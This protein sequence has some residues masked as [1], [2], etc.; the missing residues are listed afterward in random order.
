MRCLKCR[1]PAQVEVRRHRSAFCARCYPDWFRAQVQRAVDHDRMFHRDE[2]V[3]VAVSGGKDSLALWHAL[4]RLG[5]QADGMYI[6]LGIA[7]YSRRSQ[8]KAEAFADKHGL[9]LHQVDLEEGQGFTVPDLRDARSG[10]PCAACGTVKRYHFNKVAADLGY[11][12]VATGHNLDDEAAT[13][14]G[15][16]VHWQTDFLGRQGPVLESTHP[17]LV[18]KVKPLYRLAER[19]T[20]AYAIVERI[21][22]ILEECPMAKGAKSLLYKD[23]LNTLEEQQP[24]AKQRFLLGFLDGG[25]KAVSADREPVVLR[26][27]ASCGQPTTAEVCAYCRLAE[28]GRRKAAAMAARYTQA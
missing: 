11:P 19:D 24:G 18:R 1:A 22:Y 23:M 9:R 10:K 13:L 3:L 21:D 4:T 7:D 26:E 28:R 15:N 8:A 12:V 17:R 5:Y 6:R 20:A 25:R 2:R 14:F 16:V 27:C